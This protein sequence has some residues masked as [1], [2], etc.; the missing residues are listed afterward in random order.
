MGDMEDLIAININHLQT[1]GPVVW[2]KV[3]APDSRIHTLHTCT[4]TYSGPPTP[5]QQQ[6]KNSIKVLSSKEKALNMQC[7]FPKVTTGYLVGLGHVG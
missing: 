3:H 1:N 4:H 7:R 5:D 2:L 6:K